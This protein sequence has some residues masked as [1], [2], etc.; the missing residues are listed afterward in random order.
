M[1]NYQ[2]PGKSSKPFVQRKMR[3]W[4]GEEGRV[5]YRVGEERKCIEMDEEEKTARRSRGGRVHDT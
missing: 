2:Q 5:A 4:L 1:G 3:K